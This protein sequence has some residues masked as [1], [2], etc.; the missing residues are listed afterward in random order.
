MDELKE[1]NL[2]TSEEPHPIYE[3]SLLMPKEEKE[4]FDL[5]SEYKDMFGWS[6]KEIPGLDPKVT[7]HYLA[8]K[9]GVSP[10]KQP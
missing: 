9:T 1:L 4:Y 10:K 8:M 7:V 6:Y 2:K 5:L 3:S